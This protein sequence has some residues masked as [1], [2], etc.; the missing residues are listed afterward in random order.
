MKLFALAPIESRFEPRYYGLD[1]KTVPTPNRYQVFYQWRQSLR[2]DPVDLLLKSGSLPV[3]FFLLRDILRDRTSPDFKAIKHNLRKYQPRR[4]LL[5]QQLADGTWSPQADIP[6]LAPEKVATLAFLDQLEKVHTLLDLGTTLQQEKM[7]KAMIRL[8]KFGNEDGVF[9][10][11]IYHQAQLVYLA[12]QLGLDQNPIVQRAEQP[13]FRSQH[14]NGSWP[15]DLDDM[16]S[17][18]ESCYWTT[19][20]ITWSLAHSSKLRKR[21]GLERAL[22]YLREHYLEEGL[23]PILPTKE[24]WDHFHVGPSSP[25]LLHGGTLRLLE[26]LRLMDA[27]LDRPIRKM[28]NWL[29]D[30]QLPNGHWPAIVG[31][32]RRGDESVTLRVLYVFQ[33]FA[34]KQ[35]AAAYEEYDQYE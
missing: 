7:K 34:P 2:K 30:Q 18:S 35:A 12:I 33:H 16:G 20:Q 8:L 21:K 13:L 15:L 14:K 27:P 26:I 25:A 22:G 19:M 28:L 24:A 32:D 9:P 23:S 10:G 17:D 4:R 31:R 29:Q 3:R 11:R 5:A 1:S 6:N